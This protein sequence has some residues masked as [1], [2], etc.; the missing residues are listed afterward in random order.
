[1]PLSRTEIVAVQLTP[2]E[3]ALIQRLAETRRMTPSDVVRELLG[4]EGKDEN[5]HPPPLRLVSA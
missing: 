2:Y 1:M 5:G 4:L 3:H